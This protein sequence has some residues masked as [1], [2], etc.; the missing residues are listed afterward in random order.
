MGYTKLQGEKVNPI[1]REPM[2]I[3]VPPMLY[4]KLLLK[5]I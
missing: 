5:Y 1:E 2:D 4:G 3:W